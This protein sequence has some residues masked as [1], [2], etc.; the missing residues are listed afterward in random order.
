MNCVI[1]RTARKTDVGTLCLL[2]C[3]CANELYFV[4]WCVCGKGGRGG[5]TGRGAADCR[6]IGGG[7]VGIGA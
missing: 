7:A 1:P 4:F 5:V 3:L 2:S 6:V